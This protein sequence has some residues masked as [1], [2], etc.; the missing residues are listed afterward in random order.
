MAPGIMQAVYHCGREREKLVQNADCS[1]RN[2]GDWGFG[3]SGAR[4]LVMAG[5]EDRGDRSTQNHIER[6][7]GRGPVSQGEQ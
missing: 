7:R 6:G 3:L 5:P 2:H 1:L 4:A